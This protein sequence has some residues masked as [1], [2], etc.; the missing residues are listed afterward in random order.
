[1]ANNPFLSAY[2][3]EKRFHLHRLHLTINKAETAY[4]TLEPETIDWCKCII[5]TACKTVLKEHVPDWQDD[6]K[7]KLPGL[8]N[9][10]IGKSGVLNEQVLN[11][12]KTT[13]QGIA[14]ARNKDSLAGHGK[15]GDKPLIGKAEIQVFVTVCDSLMQIILAHLDKAPPD[16][17]HTTMAFKELEELLELEDFNRQT[18]TSVSVE[19][20]KKEGTLFIEGKEIRPSEILFHFDRETYAVKIQNAKQEAAQRAEE[21]LAEQLHEQAMSKI[22]HHLCEEGVFD[23][24][25]PG[26]Y[27]YYLDE[28]YIDSI[29]VNRP[30]GTATATGF[31]SATVRLG[32]SSDE[33][34]CDINYSSTFTASFILHSDDE[35]G[36]AGMELENLELEKTDWMEYEPD[37]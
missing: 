19:Y 22:D 21:E 33:D 32:A 36:T 31:V 11:G 6:D 35:C 12:I 28:I 24:F 25:H 17:R 16:I 37:D 14:E 26:H 3:F 10:A 23:N 1:M 2:A 9:Q 29:K 30:E 8:I 7:T 20:D 15:M 18:D 13:V 4:K 34:G 5:E 27:G